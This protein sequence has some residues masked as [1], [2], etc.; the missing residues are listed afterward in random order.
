MVQF[1]RVAA[2]EP[3]FREF[4]L[5]SVA[6]ALLEQAIFVADAV[7]IGGDAERRHAVEVAGREP[8]KPAVAERGVRLDLAQAIEIGAK[9]SERR[10]RRL[11]QLQVRQRVEQQAADQEFDRQVIDA[12]L[13]LALGLGARSEERY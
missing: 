5:P 13:L 12:L 11:D 4:L 1:P 7:A 9:A 8:A 2:R 6:D 10:A 3:I